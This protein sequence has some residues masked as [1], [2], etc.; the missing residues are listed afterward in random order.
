MLIIL[1]SKHLKK[2]LN[3]ACSEGIALG[4]K[5]GYKM[6]QAEETNKGFIIGSKIDQ[7]IADILREKGE[8]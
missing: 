7:E 5:L 4:Y 3:R 1:T 6:R 2:L 8:G